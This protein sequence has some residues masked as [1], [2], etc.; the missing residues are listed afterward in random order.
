ML[1]AA[2]IL[3]GCSSG[4]GGAADPTETNTSSSDSSA[5]ASSDAV[6]ETD[7]VTLYV[8]R[9]GKTMLNTTDRV[10]GW[11]DAPLTPEGED[12][13][14]AAGRGL[15]DVEFQ[16]AYSSSSGRAYQTAEI[17][18]ENSET[19]ADLEVNHDDRL[20]EFNFGTYEGDLNETM[21]TDIADSRGITLEEFMESVGPEEFANSVA[22]LDKARPESEGNWPAEDYDTIVER[23]DASID[24]IV[25]TESAKGSGN[26]LIVSH[27]LSIQALVKHLF[28]DFDM[29]G[30][31]VA[32]AAVTIITYKDGEYSLESFNDTSFIENGE[33][34]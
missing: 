34:G 8:V 21:W 33:N 31:G 25:E 19:S 20:R 9:H 4:T 29:G 6:A 7:E 2:L 30:G 14:E 16:A 3:G 32:N 18:L 1:S 23:L 26:V 15:A 12:V 13:V 27:G 17:I 5:A 11:A 10:Q 28:P 24:D 22:E